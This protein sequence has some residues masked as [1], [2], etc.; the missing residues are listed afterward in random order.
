MMGDHNIS[1]EL[2]DKLPKWL[3]EGL[4]CPPLVKTMGNHS[5]DALL[6]AMN[7]NRRENI[8]VK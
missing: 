1:S 5:P 3:A 8:S 4:T 7:P 6:E 2:Y